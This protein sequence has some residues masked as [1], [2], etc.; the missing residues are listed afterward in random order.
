MCAC[1]CNCSV[2]VWV[3][4]LFEH[5]IYTVLLCAECNVFVA[6]ENLQHCELVISYGVKSY[7]RI[8]IITSGL[9]SQFGSHVHL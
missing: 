5:C 2:C 1:V 6:V 9:E 7:I 4:E 8:V 3:G